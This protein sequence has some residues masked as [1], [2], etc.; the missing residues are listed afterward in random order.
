MPLRRGSN[1]GGRD[2]F[3]LLGPATSMG[4]LPSRVPVL[5]GFVEREAAVNGREPRRFARDDSRHPK[6]ASSAAW[7]PDSHGEITSVLQK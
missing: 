5:K 3:S 1:E 4:R 7:R 2:D 6:K